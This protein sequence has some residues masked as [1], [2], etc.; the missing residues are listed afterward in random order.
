M[1]S[2]YKQLISGRIDLHP[3]LFAIYP[4]LFLFAHNIDKTAPIE[5][6]L[7]IMIVLIMAAL[8]WAGS[9]FITKDPKKS[10]ISTSLFFIVF[11]AY[12]PTSGH[13]LKLA[14]ATSGQDVLP[15]FHYYLLVASLL[16]LVLVFYL[17]RRSDRDLGP[18]STFLNATGIILVSIS[19]AS[20]I[21]YQATHMGRESDRPARSIETAVSKKDSNYPDIY[22][23]ILDG[24]ARQ[25]IL[26]RLYFYDNSDLINFLKR[27]GFYVATESTS[28]YNTT[29]LSTASSLNMAYIQDLLPNA[30]PDSSDMKPLQKLRE[31]PSVARI[32]REYG[33]KFV[34]FSSGY[35]GT[36]LRG[37]DRYVSAPGALTEFQNVLL[38]NTAAIAFLNQA[39][40]PYDARR[41]QI[42][43][44]FDHLP[45]MSRSDSPVFVFAHILLPHPSFVF[46][47]NGEPRNPK[48]IGNVRNGDGGNFLA[49]PGNTRVGYL[50]GYREQLHFENKLV[51]QAINDILSKSKRPPIIILQSD[52]GPGSQLKHSH[53]RRSN[54]SER[55]SILNA[56]YFP[57]KR[58]ERLYKSITPVNNLKVVLDQ[59]LTHETSETTLVDDK[60]FFALGG[61]PYRFFD[62]NN[63]LRESLPSTTSADKDFVAKLLPWEKRLSTSLD[64]FEAFMEI[65]WIYFD[66]D[67]YHN[68]L[69]GFLI[70]SDLQPKNVDAI[71][72]AGLA[73]EALSF[74]DYALGQFS[75]ALKIDPNHSGAKLKKA[76]VLAKH[77][78]YNEAL[79]LLRE[80]EEAESD[81]EILDMARKTISE[82]SV[83][84]N[85][86]K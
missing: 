67:R 32:L 20:I 80:I 49:V 28:N 85:Q 63:R 8:I 41:K 42:L 12:G 1:K 61:R 31:N 70:A 17:I 82:I 29:D 23:I 9:R 64:D 79:K 10:S 56:F 2:S 3:F 14:Q 77:S 13:I 47:P 44:T 46:G 74:T 5:L 38:Q 16:V 62:V 53:V 34:S 45:D 27:K 43:W 6:A 59:Y 25:D 51:K 65:G 19:L 72:S 39:S 37:A 69:A 81:S 78:I 26:S 4:I 54:I 76:Q 33:Y 22:Y 24:Y 60:N 36:E 73:Y 86:T 55:M 84:Q 15:G 35:S 30:D 68:A 52:H 21:S 66:A 7:P 75:K 83:A 11:F 58:Y 50:K 71:I 18:F 48:D 57:D 40:V